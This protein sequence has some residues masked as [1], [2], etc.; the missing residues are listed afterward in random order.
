ME[1]NTTSVI[2]AE[3]IV[4]GCKAEL[5]VNQIPVTRIDPDQQDFVSM[6]VQQLLVDGVNSVELLLEPGLE[7]SRSRAPAEPKETEGMRALARLVRYPDGAF[8]D[9]ESGTVIMTRSWEGASGQ[10]LDFPGIFECSSDL[11]PALGRW[12]WQD[13]DRLTLDGAEMAE[14][15]RV[16]GD[17]HQAFANGEANRV[18]QLCQPRYRDGAVAYPARSYESIVAQITRM[19]Q[20]DSQRDDWQ[21]EPLNAAQWDLRLCA[22]NRMVE[23]IDRDWRPIIR[24]RTRD[25]GIPFEFPALLAKIDGQFRVVR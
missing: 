12:S 24:T 11:G 22:Q 23:A 25:D 5:Y 7:P 13:A 15:Q 21:M 1:I 19:L 20:A 14:L 8:P 4:T 9:D 17:L 2:H 18:T 3:A 6:P 16:L 10:I